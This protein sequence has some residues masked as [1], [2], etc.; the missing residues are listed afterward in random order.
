VNEAD[1]QPV[2]EVSDVRVRPCALESTDNVTRLRLL[3]RS[4][5]RFESQVNA[6][7]R[8]SERTPL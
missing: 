2:R 3:E 8:A 1:V 4:P 5:Q 6:S 7:V